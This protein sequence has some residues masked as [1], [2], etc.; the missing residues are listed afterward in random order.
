M[1]KH[2]Q[3]VCHV[4]V[5]AEADLK[6]AEK[7]IVNAKASRPGVCN[8]AECLLVDRAVASRF[9]PAAARALLK[10]GVEL[11]GCAT[12]VKLLRKAKLAVTPAKADDY[13][14]EFLSLI[15]R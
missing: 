6:K 1:V 7:I 12:T 4:Y 8:A 2:Y 13:G 9:L 14:H 15:S 3:G 11:R 5:D 10:A